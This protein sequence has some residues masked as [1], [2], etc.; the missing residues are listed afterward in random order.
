MYVHIQCVCV[1][2][3]VCVCACVRCVSMYIYIFVCAITILTVMQ[4][5]QIYSTNQ[6]CFEYSIRSCIYIILC[7]TIL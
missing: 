5:L 7:M 2:V 6:I 4:T 3:C 1:C